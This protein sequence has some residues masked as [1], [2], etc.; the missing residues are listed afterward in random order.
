MNKSSP[1]TIVSSHV[2][3]RVRSPPWSRSSLISTFLPRLQKSLQNTKLHT[4]TVILSKTEKPSMNGSRITVSKL[5]SQ[6]FSYSNSSNYDSQRDFKKVLYGNSLQ[7]AD[8]EICSNCSERNFR[9]IVSAYS[10]PYLSYIYLQDFYI[11]IHI[12]VLLFIG[13]YLIFVF[14]IQKLWW[15]GSFIKYVLSLKCFMKSW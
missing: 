10:F 9:P 2:G 6:G 15:H 13:K 14:A 7:T 4:S 3:L 1:F 11:N 5:D 8:I 12:K